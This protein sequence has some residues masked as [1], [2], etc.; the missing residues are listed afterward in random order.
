MLSGVSRGVDVQMDANERAVTGLQR[1]SDRQSV[2][3]VWQ[4][5]AGHQLCYVMSCSVGELGCMLPCYFCS[6]PLLSAPQRADVLSEALSALFHRFMA[7]LGVFKPLL[8]S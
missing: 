8:T 3:N 6:F 5:K 4:A 7:G 1:R 2:R